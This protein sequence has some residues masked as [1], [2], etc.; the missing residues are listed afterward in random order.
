M[1]SGRRQ[2]K[3]GNQAI[4]NRESAIVREIEDA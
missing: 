1:S 3:I 2:S 4:D